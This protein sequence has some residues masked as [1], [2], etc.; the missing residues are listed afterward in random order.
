MRTTRVLALVAAL[1]AS[2]L[3]TAPARAASSSAENAGSFIVT[4]KDSADPR[5]VASEY[6]R[7][8]VDVSFVY[9]H[10]LNGFAGTFSG[11]TLGRLQADGR[12]ERIE[13][14]ATATVSEVHSTPLWGLDR[15]DQHFRAGDGKFES[16]GTGDGIHVYV[17]DTGINKDHTDL[18]GRVGPGK[19]FIDGDENPVDCN[20]HGTHVAGTTAGTSYGVAK[21][22]IVHAVRVLNCRGSGTWDGVI[23]GMDWVKANAPANSVANLSL[24]GG[25]SESV[26]AAASL[27]ASKVVVAVAAGNEATNAC[28]KSPASADGVLT[29]GATDGTDTVAYYSNIG[30][31][32]ELF[33]PGSSIKSAW[34]SSATATNTISGTSMASPH[35]A[36]VAA[37]LASNGAADV[38]QRILD[39]ATVGV[40]D[41]IDESHASNRLLYNGGTLAHA[42]SV[43]LTKSC[44]SKSCTF[45]ATGR[46]ADGDALS[47]KW[48]TEAESAPV[49]TVNGAAT[50]TKTVRVTTSSYTQSVTVRNQGG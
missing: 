48:G 22:A 46:D 7:N 38:R 4:L 33:A 31:C 32:V 49:Q 9:E 30:D 43:T 25:L 12:V 36:G 42:P 1:V 47:F 26:N 21:K 11:G 19:D 41:G 28:S 2:V 37:A 44:S 50:A 14:N 8:G 13:R 3:I 16:T 20:G 24:G 29:V 6:R 34:Y 35:V 17:I 15:I 39:L 45:T 27:L 5:S 40:V 23:A 18:V 10:V